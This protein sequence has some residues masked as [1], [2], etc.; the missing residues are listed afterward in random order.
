M[1]YGRY[2]WSYFFLRMGLGITFLWIGVDVLRHP[3]VWIGYLPESVPLGLTR[4]VALQIS[5]FVDVVL[6][7]ALL[8]QVLPK[9][10]SFV[11]AAHLL[12]IIVTSGIDAGLVRN[13]G[14]LGA[15]LA[16]TFW[17]THYHRKKGWRQRIF[18]RGSSPSPED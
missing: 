12:V 11:A 9:L 10:M 14:L 5:G 8:V 6:G 4:E 13:V 2:G 17:P 1:R 16:L 18:R 7:L 15:A 3:D